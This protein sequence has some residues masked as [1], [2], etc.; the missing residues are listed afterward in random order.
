MTGM[1]YSNKWNSTDQV[2]QRAI[3]S[4]Q[5]GLYGEED[6]TDGGNTSRFALSARAAGTDDAGSWKAN[7]YVVKSELDLFNNFTYFLTDPTLGD[8]FHQHD[9]RVMTRR[10]R[11]ANPATDRSPAG[12]W[13]P[14]SA[15]RP[16]TTTSDLAL[17]DTFQ[18]SF[19]SN[20]RS[21]KV[22][23]GSV[24][25]YAQNTVALDQLAEDHARLARRL[26]CRQGQFVVRRQQFRKHR[27]PRSAVRNSPWWSGPFDKTELFFGAG[28]GMH[29]NDARGVTITEEPTDPAMKLSRIA[30]AGA[31]QGRGGRCPQQD[32]PGARYH[33]SAC[34]CSTRPPRSSST[35]TPATP[36]RACRAGATA[37]SGPTGIVRAPGSTWMPI[38]P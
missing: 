6:P 34:S 26:L 12:R 38:S 4:G 9:D 25:V 8:Q 14:R 1:A 36:R 3:A 32:R 19:L 16:A 27:L 20:V 24:G 21:D 10:Q 33:R 30:A 22:G 7:A 23:E 11:V 37:W 2:P 31:D 13:K 35:A 29:S 15:S 5:I 17:T 18:R 28:M